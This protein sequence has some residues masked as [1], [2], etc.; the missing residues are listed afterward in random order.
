L[1][2]SGVSGTPLIISDNT[3]AV[4]GGGIATSD[5]TATSLTQTAVTANHADQNAGGVHRQGGTMTTTDS[6]IS[7]NTA[8]N[9]VGSAPAVPSC[10][11]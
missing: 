6:P 4:T 5:S 10:T 11:G 1:T 2:T 8:N 9:C 3:A 7:A